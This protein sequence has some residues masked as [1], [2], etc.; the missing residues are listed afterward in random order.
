MVIRKLI[1]KVMAAVMGAI[2]VMSVGSMA[3]ANN[4]YDTESE[5][6]LDEA[7]GIEEAY[8]SGRYK[9]DASSGYIKHKWSSDGRDY[10]VALVACDNDGGT[11][12]Y[13]DFKLVYYK[14]TGDDNGQEVYLTNYVKESGYNYAA[15]KA[16]SDLESGY[17][18]DFLW[19]PDSV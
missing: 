3:F 18:I 11:E 1:T 9:D 16:C 12:Y 2:A 8:T 6:Y 10:A 5:L 14:I 13:E 4:H 15:I 7:N 19:S 17:W